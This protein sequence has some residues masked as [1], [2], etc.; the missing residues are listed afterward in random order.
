MIAQIGQLLVETLFSLLV[1]LLLIRFY[2]QALRAPFRNPV[3]EFVTGLTNWIVRPVRRVV[4]GLAGIDL[5]CLLLAW[6][7]EAVK[8]ALLNSMRGF[9]FAPAGPAIGLVLALAVVE[10][11]RDSLYLLMGVV[12]IQ[13]I[14]SWVSPY[15]DV[16]GVLNALTRPFYRLFRRF[17]PPIG[18]IDLSP[19]FVLLLAQVG[20]IL[21]GGLG[22]VVVSLFS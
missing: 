19:L 12:L 18:N 14:L 6:L 4:P 15:N 5:S 3:G 11:L 20:F 16:Q 9:S 2:M 7:G 22:R 8:L 21:V 17:I 10:L 13:V 1:Y